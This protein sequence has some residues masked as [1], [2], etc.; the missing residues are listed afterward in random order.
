[1]CVLNKC[2]VTS[3]VNKY[4]TATYMTLE[5]VEQIF[6]SIPHVPFPFLNSDSVFKQNLMS[7]IYGELC[8]ISFK[9]YI[10]PQLAQHQFGRKHS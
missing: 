10:V 8:T 3:Q 7:L 1:M 9:K 4:K 6:N 2:R 5:P